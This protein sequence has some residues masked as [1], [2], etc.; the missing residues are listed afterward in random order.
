M[1]TEVILIPKL[2]IFGGKG[3]KN[4]YCCVEKIELSL[5]IDWLAFVVTEQNFFMNSRM[6]RVLIDFS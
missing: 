2:I 6:W 3:G 5:L 1:I 4:I